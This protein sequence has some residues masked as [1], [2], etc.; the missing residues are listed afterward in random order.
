MKNRI[1]LIFVV[2]SIAISGAFSDVFGQNGQ[3]N[4]HEYVDLG[5][6][7]GLL[8]ATCN[9]GANS[10]EENGNYYAWGETSTKDIY[11]EKTYKYFKGP[12]MKITKY[13]FYSYSG[14]LDCLA[15]LEY[16]DD[17]VKENWGGEWQMPTWEDMKELYSN[18]THK[19]TTQNGVNGRMFTG[20][21]GNSIFL[22]AAGSRYDSD[23]KGIK[24]S[25]TYWSSSLNSYECSDASGLCFN[26]DTCLIYTDNRSLGGSVRAVCPSKNYISEPTGYANGYGYIDLGLPSGTK[27]A[28]C[29]IGALRSS[30]YGDYFAWGETR[31][32]KKYGANY[33]YNKHL[34]TLPPKSDAATA[35]MGAGWRMPMETEMRELIN[36]CTTTGAIRNGVYGRLLTGPNGNSIFLPAAG[37]IL[38]KSCE[39][40]GNISFYRSSSLNKDNPE[41]GFCIYFESEGNGCSLMYDDGLCHGFSVRAIYA[42]TPTLETCPA[43]AITPTGATLYG[44]I[45]FEGVASVKARGFVYGTNSND[46]TQTVH[47]DN[48]TKTFSA[49]LTGLTE[50]TTYYYKAYATNSDGTSYGEV[51][52]FTAENKMGTLA[53]HEWVDLGLPSGTCWATCN[54]GANRPEE[55]GNDYAWGETTPKETY[56]WSTYKYCNGSEYT[57][58]KYCSTAVYG[59]NGYAD[60]LTTLE[61]SDDVATVNWGESWR[62]PNIIEIEELYNNCTVITVK[63]NGVEGSLF[64]GPNGNS[65]F[66]PYNS[67]NKELRHINFYGCYWSSSL[68]TEKSGN[69]WELYIDSE[70]CD[71]ISPKRYY[72][73]SVRPVCVK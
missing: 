46:L 71:T 14:K 48:R 23:N 20:P 21:N 52:S 62:M 42:G 8:W 60:S 56:E 49:T 17:V 19:W 16:S 3:L 40:P 32:K 34:I 11:N 51:M 24:N 25:G 61:A 55:Y 47:S 45:I 73:L 7:S 68:F 50:G 10:P 69:A 33:R 6:P 2:V 4:G 31:T 28:I 36:N 72:G 70:E 57:L 39:E 9:I 13:N 66:L 54:V 5:L 29:N 18:C 65:I 63:R 67:S 41:V 22:P 1:F 38:G 35:N 44:D 30:D 53:G 26:S 59:N 43:T 58:T 64:I 27:W 15:T 37:Y 12:N